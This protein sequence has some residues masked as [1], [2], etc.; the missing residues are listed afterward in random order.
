MKELKRM[1]I[2]MVT[3]SLFIFGTLETNVA[4][5]IT[6][7]LV[8]VVSISAPYHIVGAMELA[9]FVEQKTQG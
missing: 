2:G 6:L 3:V 7:K 5:P 8:H 1:L 9:K 4:A